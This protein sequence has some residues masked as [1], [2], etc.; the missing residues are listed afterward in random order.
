MPLQKILIVLAVLNSSLILGQWNIQAGY[1]FGLIKFPEANNLDRKVNLNS[2][3]RT[4]VVFESIFKNGFLLSLTFGYDQY[5]INA[6]FSR[7]TESNSNLR[8]TNF[9]CDTDL[10]N[11]RSEIGAGYTWSVNDKINLV[12]K[13]NLGVFYLY[14]YKINI[15][16]VT[17]QSFSGVNTSNENLLV[18]SS[19]FV[20][21]R[22]FHGDY[23]VGFSPINLAFEYR[24][25]AKEYSFNGFLGYAIMRR[26]FTI[27]NGSESSI[28]HIFILGIRLGYTFPKKKKNEK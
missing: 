18:S 16:E 25:K 14:S 11:F 26:G 19:Q 10:R 22:D 21:F 17:N 20:D 9:L 27:N 12:L 24:Y 6:D 23:R 2:V 28:N 7:S 8:A 5:N 15:S 3:H 4:N 1:D 13:A